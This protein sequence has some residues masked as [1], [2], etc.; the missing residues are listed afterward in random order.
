MGLPAVLVILDVYPLR[1][2]GGGPGR[3]FGPAARRVWLEKVPFVAISLV[4]MAIAVA[5]RA[6]VHTIVPLEQDGIASRIA[7]ACYGAWF[8]LV[9]TAI[10]MDI[11][12]FYPLPGRIDWFAPPFLASIGDP[13]R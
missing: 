12:A 9:K 4:F 2:L 5:A 7:Q 11:A 3:W 6:D 13:W 1:R 8:Y 10:P